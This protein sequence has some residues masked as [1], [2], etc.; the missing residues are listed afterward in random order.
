[1]RKFKIEA[2]ADTL[3]NQS[4]TRGFTLIE[5]LVVIAIIAILAA[6]LLPAL[7]KSK[8]QAQGIQCMNNEKQLT[9]AWKL[10]TGDNAG[11][12]V[13]NPG[14]DLDDGTTPAWVSDWM[15]YAPNWADNTNTARLMDSRY[16][17]LAPYTGSAG[18]YKCPADESTALEGGAR[19]P[20]IRSVSM[21]AAV[22]RGGDIYWLNY[23]QPSAN[24]T[25]FQK[26]SDYGR[27]STSMLWVFDDEHPDS[28]N[29]G[30]FAAAVPP[31]LASTTWIDVLASYHNG[32]CGLGFADGHAE[33]HKWLDRRSD[34]PVE[35]NGYLYPVDYTPHPQPYNQDLMWLG[36]RASIATL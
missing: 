26:E 24:F 4:R 9:L 10:Y 25:L 1:M 27:M 2:A 15:D 32:A 14:G 16:S 3:P 35:Y 5:L 30:C 23:L 22:G 8:V 31:T 28:I 7:V 19:C 20:R 18:I 29:D 6:L 34:F 13:Y 36:Q 12:L 11:W 21:N 17:M 33:V